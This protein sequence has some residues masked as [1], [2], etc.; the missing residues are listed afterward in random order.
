MGVS[1]E[2]QEADQV[3]L[4]NSETKSVHW[5]LLKVPLNTFGLHSCPRCYKSLF[6][7]MGQEK[8]SPPPWPL[9][10]SEDQGRNGRGEG[11]RW[12]SQERAL[13]GESG[14]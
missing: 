2:S 11:D 13:D 6:L 14:G 9:L 3:L 4:S 7:L 12:T 1:Q 8:E 5:D 10:V